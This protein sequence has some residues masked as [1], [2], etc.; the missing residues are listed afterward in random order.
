MRLNNYRD[1]LLKRLADPEYAV[2][3]LTQVLAEK[4]NAA[5]L[6]AGRRHGRTCRARRSQAAQPL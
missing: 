2:E 5:F 4:D 1:D 3:Y 6:I